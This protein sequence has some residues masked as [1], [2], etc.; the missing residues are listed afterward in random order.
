MA[1]ELATAY[2]RIRPDSAGFKTEAE[3]GIRAGMSNVGKIIGG[4]FAAAGVFEA[5]KSIVEAAAVHQSAFAVVEQTLKNAHQS[6][7][8]YGQ[9]VESLLEKEARLKG[10]SD[11]DLASSFIRLVSATGDAGKAFKD[12]GLAEDVA[13]ARH[14]D[15]GNAALA[16]SRAEQGS[17][18]SLSRLGVVVPKVNTEVA[19]LTKR[20]EEA[21]ASGAKFSKSQDLI[22]KGALAQAAV[23]D[24]AANRVHALS[25]VQDRFGGSATKFAD[26]ASG[27][28]QRAEQNIHQ[29][30]VAV[31]RDALPA[32]NTLA[33]GVGHYAQRLT[34]SESVQSAVKAG[35]ADIGAVAH[36]VKAVIETVGP[37]F[38]DAAKAGL[39]LVDAVGSP[40]ILTAI[41]TYKGLG[42]ALGLAASAEA[43][44]QRVIA[45]GTAVKAAEVSETAALTTALA[46][47][48]EALAANRAAAASGIAANAELGASQA[49]LAVESDA[50][51]TGGVATFARGIGQL[52]LAAVGGPVGLAIIGLAGLAGGI[53]YAATRTS[54]FDRAAG[55]LRATLGLLNSDLSRTKELALAV[56]QSKIDVALAK[57]SKAAADAAVQQAQAN[58]VATRG[59]S[60]HAD[61]V[62][63]LKTAR[64]QD[65]A[66]ALAVTRSEQTVQQ[67]RAG[68]VKNEE[69]IAQARRDAIRHAIQA[70]DATKANDIPVPTIRFGSGPG[71]KNDL[72]FQAEQLQRA[73]DHA[74]QFARKLSTLAQ[75][76]EKA[77]GPGI[78]RSIRLLGQY[79]TAL[80]RVPDKHEVK[81]I[82][83]PTNAKLSLRQI[84]RDLGTEARAARTT[85]LRAGHDL[86][87]SLS[88]GVRSGID[89]T[90]AKVAA[91]IART[92][93]ATVAAGKSAARAHSPSE[94]TAQEIGLPLAQGIVV[95]INTGAPEVQR[96]L[97]DTIGQAVKQGGQ[98]VADAINQAKQNLNSIG[99]S[100]ASTISDVLNRPFQ[101]A[102]ARLGAAQNRKTLSDLRRSIVLPGGGS[103]TGSTDQAL[104][105]LRRLP[106]SGGVSDVIGQFQTDALAVRQD[107]VTA[108]TAAITRQI[109]DLTDEFNK[110]SISGGKL[111]SGV[112]AILAKNHID[113]RKI[114][115]TQGIAYAD[116][117]AAELKG[118]R[119]QVVALVGSP[120][121][122]GAGL[123]P[124]SV[125]PIDTL[126]D[127]TQ[128]VA[129]AARDQRA[130]QLAEA[131]RQTA[132]QKK[133]TTLAQAAANKQKAA[134]F[135]ASLPKGERAAISKV[136]SGT[137]G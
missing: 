134:D 40:A 1:G 66:A 76:Q 33:E 95:G 41:G 19:A 15:V 63:A 14:I 86:G 35:M 36:D 81:F 128:Q 2:V 57:D 61:A 93:E 96:A 87:V 38:L 25:V 129:Q 121:L 110:G 109:A 84:E 9:S 17:T 78:A 90:Q 82:L 58:E 59:T 117:F 10:F 37:P 45:A 72:A 53:A 54:D 80:G 32:I 26:T 31:G 135:I 101:Q 68:Q 6:T 136:L 94:L 16:L 75:E 43:A 125:R 39:Q 126:R 127:V 74:D 91:G 20:H 55:S 24:K 133:Q 92:V 51:A 52:G 11:E 103:L 105:E 23:V 28:F 130:Q 13:R 113:I 106:K 64:D 3:S 85:A 71:P 108:R 79:A 29:L 132:E 44:Y 115:R 65:A 47:N 8:L 30:E 114:A 70:A 118:L 62:L 27:Q 99:S 50:A 131:K 100:L 123:A 112:S 77:G 4:A 49:A 12:L 34:E 89:D 42:I 18:Q 124:S 48:T 137:T 116:Q 5:A 88:E 107:Q 7:D 60:K 73:A 119:D 67:A 98:Q 111:T 69:A 83:D 122:P 56:A 46:A 120:K 97:S 21:V 104:A 22:Y 102:Q